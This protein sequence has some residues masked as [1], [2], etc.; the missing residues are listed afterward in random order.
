ML[1]EEHLRAALMHALLEGDA[2]AAGVQVGLRA[3]LASG[4]TASLKEPMRAVG[5]EVAGG[6]RSLSATLDA[7]Q[8]LVAE[9]SAGLRVAMRGAVYLTQGYTE[10]KAR[11]EG[12]SLQQAADSLASRKAELSA[13][14]RVNAAANS[15]LD[16][17]AIL[18]TVVQVVAEVTGAAVC[19]IYLLQPPNMLVLAATKGLNPSAVGRARMAVGEGITGFAA[20]E[21][22]TVAVPDIWRDPRAN[23]LPETSEDPFHSMIS[24]PIINRSLDRLLGVLNVQT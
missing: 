21:R 3:A 9:A 13:L 10:V 2:D 4:D 6:G 14:H 19:S 23:Y 7:W 5:R 8:D 15:S 16:E 1:S 18:S 24:V 11:R 12:A 20:R 17:R 22:C